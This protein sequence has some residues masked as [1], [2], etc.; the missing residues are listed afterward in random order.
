MYHFNFKYFCS[1]S[2]TLEYTVN[3]ADGSH[4]GDYVCAAT[5]NK[6]SAMEIAT[7]KIQVP[8]LS[9]T[10]PSTEYFKLENQSAVEIQCFI[11]LEKNFQ[12]TWLF[13][14][15]PVQAGNE[16][17]VNTIDCLKAVHFQN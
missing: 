6:G 3:S 4:D 7:V 16:Y 2:S 5:N 8:P 11:S 1:Q 9:V 15:Q 14:D 12:Q 13:N 17:E 10:I